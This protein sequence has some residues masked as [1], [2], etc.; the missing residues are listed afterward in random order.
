[1]RFKLGNLN[2]AVQ[3]AERLLELVVFGKDTAVCEVLRA[4]MPV[5]D[6]VFGEAAWARWIG[7]LEI[8]LAA[9]DPKKLNLS[10]QGGVHSLVRRGRPRSRSDRRFRHPA[11][12]RHPHAHA[13][14]MRRGA[15]LGPLTPRRPSSLARAIDPRSAR[16]AREVVPCTPG[17]VVH[18]SLPRRAGLRCGSDDSSGGSAGTGGATGSGGSAGSDAGCAAPRAHAV[19]GSPAF[20]KKTDALGAHRHLDG[21]RIIAQDLDAD[22]YPD[23]VVHAI[24]STNTR[25]SARRGT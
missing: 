13:G 23:L 20:Q 18:T 4:A 11:A 24:S 10:G 1:M 22:G 16:G 15:S 8:T 19:S 14:L 21:N 6:Q 12:R 2:E 9:R 3:H 7:D 5:V 17:P 25:G